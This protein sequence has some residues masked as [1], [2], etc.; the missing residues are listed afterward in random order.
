MVN[1]LLVDDEE[2]I[3]DFLSSVLKKMDFNVKYAMSGEDAL[4]LIQQETFDVAVVDFKLSTSITGLTVIK[5]IREKY[6]KTIV[7]AMSGYVDVGLAQE[8]RRL[9]VSDYLEKPRDIQPDI[10]L[11]KIQRLLSQRGLS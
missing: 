2:D 7:V 11:K 9:G 4:T 8:T 10:F 3:C 1:F 6:P 5:E